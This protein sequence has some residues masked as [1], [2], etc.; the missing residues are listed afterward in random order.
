MSMNPIQ[1][2]ELARAQTMDQYGKARGHRA[3]G[4]ASPKDLSAHQAQPALGDQAEIS[5]K[6]RALVDLRGALDAGR[7]AVD[8]E[9]ET[10][11]ERLATVRERLESGFYQSATVREKVAGGLMT[12]M[13]GNDIL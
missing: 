11:A 12:V 3:D 8:R 2:G 4:V 5:S 10:R 9:P 1:A 13:F 6:A 7:A